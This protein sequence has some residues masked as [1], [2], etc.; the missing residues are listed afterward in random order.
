M[1]ALLPTE[2]LRRLERPRVFERYVLAKCACGEAY[3]DVYGCAAF[4]VLLSV[5]SRL[6]VKGSASSGAHRKAPFLP[7]CAFRSET[8]EASH[9]SSRDECARET[10]RGNWLREDH[11]A[12]A[13]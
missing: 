7:R 11:D 8:G 3:A 5:L 13:A 6:R 10:R 2:R 9:G 12:E 4:D 1:C